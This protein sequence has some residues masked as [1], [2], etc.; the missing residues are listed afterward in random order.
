V[1]ETP[2]GTETTRNNK[3]IRKDTADP[4]FLENME[5]E[6]KGQKAPEVE[7]VS[8]EEVRH[9]G[10]S[11]V[12]RAIF[13]LEP[14]RKEVCQ[15]VVYGS[16]KVRAK[17]GPRVRSREYCRV[18]TEGAAALDEAPG[19][20]RQTE[21][22]RPWYSPV[23]LGKGFSKVVCSPVDQDGTEAVCGGA[24]GA[25]GDDPDEAGHEVLLVW[26]SP[27]RVS[28]D[29][30]GHDRGVAHVHAGGR[31]GALLDGD[32]KVKEEG[33]GKEDV[34]TANSHGDGPDEDWIRCREPARDD[35]GVQGRRA[36]DGHGVRGPPSV[37]TR[38]HAEGGVRTA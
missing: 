1:L 22:E 26:V 9:V 21:R 15:I 14:E 2:R 20:S 8:E 18:A 27:S 38:V 29:H 10:G 36:A 16:P 25:G 7:A 19:V 35:H 5:A 34:R 28:C 23:D 17:K 13:D 4:N 31:G 12:T 6:A 30:C 37:C 32:K 3:Y 33:G 11:A 24:A